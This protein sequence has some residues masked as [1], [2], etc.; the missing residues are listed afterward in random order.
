MQHLSFFW[1]RERFLYVFIFHLF[2]NIS[3]PIFRP[4]QIWF[5]REFQG[6]SFHNKRDC[7][8]R[9]NR[10]EIFKILRDPSLWDNE[11]CFRISFILKTKSATTK[12][13]VICEMWSFSR[14]IVWYI[15][16]FSIHCKRWCKNEM[17]HLTFFWPREIVKC[18]QPSYNMS[19][20]PIKERNN[21]IENSFIICQ[22]QWSNNV[23]EQWKSLC[24]ETS[25]NILL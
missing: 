10:G 4:S 21:F 19:P 24:N 17:E 13:A 1:P 11:W 22:N 5:C 2:S 8:H 23:D 7:N 18:H 12:Q 15:L 9:D 20:W 3:K 25:S 6:L 16:F 14:C